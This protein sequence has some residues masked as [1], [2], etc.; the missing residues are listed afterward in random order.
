M[1]QFKKGGV[2][3]AFELGK[4]NFVSCDLQMKRLEAIRNNSTYRENLEKAQRVGGYIDKLMV[5]SSAKSVDKDKIRDLMNQNN[6]AERLSRQKGFEDESKS[7]II[8][9]HH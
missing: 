7:R 9:A 2:I 4:G 8:I 1:A 3:N 6:K 5:I